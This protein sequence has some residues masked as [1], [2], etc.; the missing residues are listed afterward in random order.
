MSNI[1]QYILNNKL[2]TREFNNIEYNTLKKKFR[3]SQNLLSGHSYEKPWEG[4]GQDKNNNLS[5]II[6]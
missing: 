3:K 6:L 2:C 5:N 4:I 1:P